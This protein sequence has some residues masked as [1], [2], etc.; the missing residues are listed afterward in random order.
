MSLPTS[1][2]CLQ[3]PSQQR[4]PWRA[5]GA[6]EGRWLG[7]EGR[8]GPQGQRGPWEKRTGSQPQKAPHGQVCGDPQGLPLMVLPIP[9]GPYPSPASRHASSG[10]QISFPPPLAPGSHQP[11]ASAFPHSPYLVHG[12]T[13]SVWSLEGSHQCL[14][15]VSGLGRLGLHVFSDC[16]LPFGLEQSTFKGKG[17]EKLA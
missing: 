9:G 14:V 15:D 4:G 5:E 17:R 13:L 2:A 3:D 7:W 10:T 11:P 8:E 16:H 1:L 12:Y 6:L